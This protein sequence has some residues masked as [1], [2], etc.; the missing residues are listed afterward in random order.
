VMGLS[1]RLPA[2]A[3]GAHLIGTVSLPGGRG[4]PGIGVQACPDDGTC[5]QTATR[6]DGTFRLPVDPGSYRIRVFDEGGRYPSGYYSSHGFDRE[7]SRASLVTVASGDVRGLNVALVAAYRIGGRLTGPGGGPAA[8]IQVLACPVSSG[9]CARGISAADGTY[10]TTGLVPSAYVVTFND[11]AGDLAAAVYRSAGWTDVVAQATNVVLG[12]ADVGS[13]DLQLRAGGHV[14]G[15][16]VDGSGQPADAVRVVACGAGRACSAVETDSD[17]RYRLGVAPGL[18][19]LEFYGEA[20]GGFVDGWFSGSGL[21]LSRAAASPL[22]VGTGDRELATI[23]LSARPRVTFRTGASLSSTGSGALVP[24]LARWPSGGAIKT[25]RV[26]TNTDGGS[27]TTV[28]TVSPTPSAIRGASLSLSMGHAHGVRIQDVAPA[29]AGGTVGDAVRSLPF[30]LAAIQ[31]SS[32]RLSFDGPWSTVANGTASGAHARTAT[33]SGASVAVTFIG[34]GIAWV[35][36]TGPAYGSAK[37]FV[38]GRLAATVSA[39]AGAGTP[40]TLLWAASWIGVGEHTVQ[41]VANGTPG[42]PRIEFDAFVV[43]Q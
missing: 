21:T 33:H 35:G 23:V 2:G 25:T 42:H 39:S 24:V 28:S 18:A 12:T 31:E 27:F 8:D 4:A 6:A 14:S 7:F 15:T 40:R 1:I 19:T 22:S 29:A 26:A 16:I 36:S 32:S 10:L 20:D 17:G 38:D 13:I 5:R 11:P 9:Y 3:N 34:R 43:L 41:I 37:V 30:T